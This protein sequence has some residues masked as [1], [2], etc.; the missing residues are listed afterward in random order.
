MILPFQ[1]NFVDKPNIIAV[2]DHDLQHLGVKLQSLVVAL[3]H[4][5][6]HFAAVCRGKV[7]GV[8]LDWQQTGGENYGKVAG[9]H[10]VQVGALGHVVKMAK[11]E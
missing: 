3:H 5:L 2:H 9:C 4:L 10:L 1:N 8:I 11:K 7:A 6:V